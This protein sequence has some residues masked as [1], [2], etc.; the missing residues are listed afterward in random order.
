MLRHVSVGTLLLAI[1][2]TVAAA[3]PAVVTFKI[4]AQPG[5]KPISRFIYGV[6]L[7]LEGAWADA[8]FTRVGGNRWTAYNW[9]HNASNAGSDWQFQNDAYLGGG[10]V[11]GGALLPAIKNAAARNAGLILT[12]P[13]AGYVAADKKGDGDFRKKDPNYLQ[14]RF[15]PTAAAKGA[16]FTLTP[17]PNSAT[18]Y[19]DELVNWIKAQTP[20]AATDDKRP[21]FFALDNEPDLWS[22]THAEIHPK[23]ATYEEL[24]KRSVDYSRAIKAVTPKTL[25]FGPVN[26]GWMGFVRLQNAPD[27]KDRDFQEV[28]LDAMAQAEKVAGKRLLDVLDVHWYPEAQGGGKR[29]TEGGNAAAVVAARLQAPRSLWDPKYVEESWIT[30]DVLRGPINLLPRLQEKIAKHYPGTLLAVTE[31]NYG[32]GDHISG[33]LAEA[34]VLGIFGREGVFAAAMWP[35]A[36]NE[37]FIA[38]GLQMYRNFD[39]KG[40]TFGDTSASATTDAPAETSVYASLDSTNPKRMVIVAINKTDHAVPARVQIAHGKA[41]T[42]AE[43]YQLTAAGANPKPAGPLTLANPAAFDYTMPPMSA[44]TIVLVA[45]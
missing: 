18:V 15:R 16:A 26:Y 14:T 34:D 29:I 9:T 5:A 12:I 22:S 30:K 38:A 7:P 4:D 39:G 36:K 8:A 45:P 17:D 23:P 25:I 19:A 40:G 43:A 13:M 31:Y 21:V 3:E 42:K 6:N 24:I 28:Y 20:Y 10:E 11:P 35:M 1:A 27:A 44:S 33:G 41:Y 2:S 37:T 32:G